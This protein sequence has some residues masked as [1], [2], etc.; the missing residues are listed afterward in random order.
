MNKF[1]C[2]LAMMTS[3]HRNRFLLITR[4][5]IELTQNNV[6]NVDRKPRS[7]NRLVL[8]STVYSEHFW[9]KRQMLSFDTLEET[10]L[11]HQ[12]DIIINQDLGG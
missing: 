3:Y 5:L 11:H 7:V 6:L 8:L 1:A 2:K 10:I 9:R 12:D 4:F